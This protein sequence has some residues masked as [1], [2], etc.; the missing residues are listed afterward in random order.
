MRE[1]W[2]FGDRQAAG[3]LDT[4]SKHLGVGAKTGNG[5]DFAKLW[6]EDREKAIAYLRNDLELCRE[7]SKKLGVL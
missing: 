3:S 5:K 6:I 1:I 2:Q 4:I 7:I